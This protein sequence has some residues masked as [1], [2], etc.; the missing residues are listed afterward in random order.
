M[1]LPL[2]QLAYKTLLMFKL[3]AFLLAL[4][5]LLEIKLLKIM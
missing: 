4:K 3:V 1:D 5:L 2:F